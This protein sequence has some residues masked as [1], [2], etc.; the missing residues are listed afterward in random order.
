[1]ISNTYN[2][3]EITSIRT[4]ERHL[5]THID[6]FVPDKEDQKAEVIIQ[7]TRT[8]G[9]LLKL[10]NQDTGTVFFACGMT[11]IDITKNCDGNYMIHWSPA[12]Y[13]Y[14][15]YVVQESDIDRIIEKAL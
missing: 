3:C 2:S 15:N 4:D 9:E 10:K 1:M 14:C 7:G 11:N 8:K 12:D 5:C 6:L 13:H